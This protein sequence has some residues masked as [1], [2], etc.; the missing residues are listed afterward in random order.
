MKLRYELLNFFQR[1]FVINEQKP[2]GK[3]T[4]PIDP[5]DLRDG[6]THELNPNVPGVREIRPLSS[7]SLE[8]RQT[9]LLRE[10]YF[11]AGFVLKE[12]K[13]EGELFLVRGQGREKTVRLFAANDMQAQ[14]PKN[15]QKPEDAVAELYV[16][17]ALQ[18]QRTQALARPQITQIPV[19]KRNERENDGPGLG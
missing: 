12:G 15:T 4:S 13:E 11:A 14:D 1:I 19:S 5:L 3:A 7:L 10:T 2:A 6:P 8:Q 18:E 9:Y 16:Q 17:M